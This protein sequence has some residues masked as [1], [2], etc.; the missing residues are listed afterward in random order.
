[1]Q[2]QTT[3]QMFVKS[4]CQVCGRATCPKNWRLMF[5]AVGLQDQLAHHL[6]QL[7]RLT[8]LRDDLS[9]FVSKRC[10]SDPSRAEDALRLKNEIVNSLCAATCVTMPKVSAANGTSIPSRVPIPSTAIVEQDSPI[11][12]VMS[13]S[14]LTD[15][16]LHGKHPPP[17]TPGSIQKPAPKENQRVYLTIMC[18]FSFSTNKG[19]S[20]S[21]WKGQ[22]RQGIYVVW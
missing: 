10:V 1:M 14:P 6:S 12:S 15:Y 4:G 8:V 21:F 18:T 20:E 11:T 5:T 3:P 19:S 16:T 22:H 9:E 7:S 2:V 13:Q 17:L